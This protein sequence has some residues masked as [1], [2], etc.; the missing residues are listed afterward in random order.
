VIREEATATII[1][2]AANDTTVTGRTEGS[3]FCDLD[4]A[5]EEAISGAC[6]LVAGCRAVFSLPV[7]GVD[8]A[9]GV[10][11][12]VGTGTGFGVGFGVDASVGRG[13]GFGVDVGFGGVSVL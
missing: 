2:M 13:V 10:G 9:P 3:V 6:L 7:N 1:T 11:A 12:S 4:G 5:A 8:G